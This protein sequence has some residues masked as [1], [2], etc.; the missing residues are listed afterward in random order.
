MRHDQ[1]NYTRQPRPSYY[2]RE[3]QVR[4]TT[5]VSESLT[6]CARGCR[7]REKFSVDGAT[8]QVNVVGAFEKTRS[9]SDAM[10]SGGTPPKGRLSD[11]RQRRAGR[12]VAGRD[13]SFDEFGSTCAGTVAARVREV[14]RSACKRGVEPKTGR[15]PPAERAPRIAVS[16]SS[17]GSSRIPTS[18][19]A[20]A[21]RARAQMTALEH[22]PPTEEHGSSSGGSPAPKREQSNVA[23]Y[24]LIAANIAMP[25]TKLIA[26]HSSS[27]PNA[28]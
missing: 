15:I 23:I 7:V 19:R 25:T 22:H 12:G 26:E 20:H 28:R 24:A 5:A 27:S 1:H 21:L 9:I 6:W 4:T 2:Q 11:V 17:R 14:D 16:R 8:A 18:R 3:R 10:P 13:C